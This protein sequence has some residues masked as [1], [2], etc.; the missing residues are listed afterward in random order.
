[1]IVL[2]GRSPVSRQPV[3]GP[4]ES[5]ATRLASGLPRVLQIWQSCVGWPETPRPSDAAMLRAAASFAILATAAAQVTIEVEISAGFGWVVNSGN[6]PYPDIAANVRSTLR[7]RL[8]SDGSALTDLRCFSRRRSATP[9]PSR[10][11]RPTTTLCASET[12]TPTA[13]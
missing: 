6:A 9:S 11:R 7:T 13:T 12:A 4:S 5:K 10:T 2:L 1:M 8:G 3:F